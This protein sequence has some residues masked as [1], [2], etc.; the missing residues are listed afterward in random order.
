VAPGADVVGP[1]SVI[2]AAK[3]DGV[4]QI[5]LL[6]AYER[7]IAWLHAAQQRVLAELDGSAL[8]WTGKRTVD[9]TEVARRTKEGKTKKEI[10]RCLKRHA[11]REIYTA[12]TTDFAA[13]R[14]A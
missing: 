10:I 7:Q 6:V 14:Q 13:I 2:D 5:D 4:G 12:L 11:I 8:D 1:L 3:V 9:Y